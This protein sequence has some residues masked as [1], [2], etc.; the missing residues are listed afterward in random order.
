MGYFVDVT[1]SGGDAVRAYRKIKRKIKR[2][3]LGCHASAANIPLQALIRKFIRSPANT[4]KVI[5]IKDRPP[6]IDA[7]L[8][9]APMAN[10]TIMLKAGKP[11]LVR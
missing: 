3:Q 9:L 6:M 5:L 11:T 2:R 8:G 7:S 4:E 10:A 1:K